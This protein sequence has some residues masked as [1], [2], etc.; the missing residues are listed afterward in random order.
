[1]MIVSDNSRVIITL[2]LKLIDATRGVIYDCH[3][4]IVQTTEEPNLKIVFGE[5]LF[6]I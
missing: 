1:M 2:S 3:M 6:I 4:F 5:K